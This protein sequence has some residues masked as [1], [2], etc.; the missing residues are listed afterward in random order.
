MREHYDFSEM[1]GRK[2]PYTKYLKRPITIRFDRVGFLY[3]FGLSA[4]VLML[5]GLP[6][7]LH[8]GCRSTNSFCKIYAKSLTRG[9]MLAGTF[10]RR[11]N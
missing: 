3:H 9:R 11:L 7:D 10:G 8:R 4:K 5:L 6:R 2:N 1:K